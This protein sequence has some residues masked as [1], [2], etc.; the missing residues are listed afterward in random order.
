MTLLLNWVKA[1]ILIVLFSAIILISIPAGLFVSAGMNESVREKISSRVK[2]TEKSLKK[3]ESTKVE[4]RPLLPGAKTFDEKMVVTEKTLEQTI[5][6]LQSQLENI[7]S[8]KDEML[9]ALQQMV[10]Q[11]ASI[12]KE[13]SGQ[14]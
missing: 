13:I 4:I 3:V 10:K 12:Q 14:D 11:A 7:E 2:S 9:S 1:H 8:Y 6:M 5:E